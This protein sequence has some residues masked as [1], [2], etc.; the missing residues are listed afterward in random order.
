MPKKEI[1]LKNATIISVYLL[2]VWGFYRFLFKLP[3]ELEELVI[4]PILWLGPVF[5]FLK[6]ELKGLPS[7]GITS[8]NLFPA[9]YYALFLGV[10]FAIEGVL[11]NI[12][13]HKTINFDANTIH[14]IGLDNM[15]GLNAVFSPV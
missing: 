14:D 3:E 1:A 8:K 4:K 6:K 2:I 13:K 11:I 12:V 9:I 7:I 15:N 5:Y 10:I